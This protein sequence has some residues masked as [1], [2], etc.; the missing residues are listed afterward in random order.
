MLQPKV[1]YQRHR[2]PPSVIARAVWLYIRFPLSLRLV[3]EMLLERGIVVSYETVRCWAK[4][5]GPDYAGRLRRKPPSANDVCYLDE[6]VVTMGGRKHWL[7]RAVDQDGYVLDEIVQSRRNT[8]A[9]KRLL[10][11]LMKKQGCLPKRIVAE[12]LRSLWRGTTPG[13]AD[14]RASIA[15]GPEQSRRELASA[16]AKTRTG[17][18]RISIAGGLQTFLFVFSAVRNLFVPP[19]SKHSALASHLHR[20]RAIAGIAA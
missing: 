12:K 7:W 5:F 16:F 10:V 17:H 2:Y 20:L 1:S 19:H 13:H 11:R 3:E 6:V 15:Q 18:A 14:R 4:K 8:K 9:T